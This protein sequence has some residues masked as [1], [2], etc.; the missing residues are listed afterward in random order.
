[1]LESTELSDINDDLQKFWD[2]ETLDMTFT[3]TRYQVKLPFKDNQ[4]MLPDN[5]TVA[6]RRLTTTIK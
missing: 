6:L 2:L 3:G 1:M 4:L 5:Y